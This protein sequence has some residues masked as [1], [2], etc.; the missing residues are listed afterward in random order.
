MPVPVVGEIE[1]ARMTTV[2]HAML[3]SSHF[4]PCGSGTPATALVLP[5]CSPRKPLA[6]DPNVSYPHHTP[7]QSFQERRPGRM[8]LASISPGCSGELKHAAGW[9]VEEATAATP[10]TTTTPPTTL[11]STTAMTTDTTH[12]TTTVGRG[13]CSVGVGVAA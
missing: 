10:T 13:L 4:H 8:R 1:D 3:C 2:A 9:G 11:T 7:L 12:T 5:A 6:V